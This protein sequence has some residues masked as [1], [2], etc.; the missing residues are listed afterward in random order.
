[1]KEGKGS[2]LVTLWWLIGCL[3]LGILLVV[4]AP[5]EARPSTTENRMLAGAPVLNKES[6]FSGE[7]FSGVEDYMSD[8][9]FERETIID[10]SDELLASFDLRTEEQRLIAEEAEIDRL[11]TM[12]ASGGE[13]S[14]TAAAAGAVT[15]KTIPEPTAE[16]TAEPTPE[17]TAEPT[18]EPTAEPTPEPTA[19]PTP[20]PTAEPTPEP[21]AEPTPEPTTE[22]TPEPTAEPTAE[23]TIEPTRAATPVPTPTVTPTPYAT[24][25][26]APTKAPKEIVPLEEGSTYALYLIRDEKRKHKN[27]T[28]PAENIMHFAG[29]LNYLKTLL[30]EDGEIHYMQV[31]VA[32]VGT[33]L[34]IN[35]S[36]FIG[37][38]STME[39][40]LQSQVEDNIF[41]HNIPAILESHLVAKEKDLYFFTDHHWTP[42]GAWYALEAV[43]QARGL[44]VVG[45]DEY[46][47]Q[48]KLMDDNGSG[49][50]D[51]I[52]AMY[53]LAPVSGVV[54]TEK[55]VE[56]ES[57]LINYR[58]KDYMAFLDGTKTPWRRFD[59][60]YGT[61]RKALVICDSF[62][63][64]FVPYLL[65][66]YDEVHMTDLRN[67]YY[68]EEAA[69]GTFS[70]LVRYH[71]IDDIYV[72][73]STSNGINAPNSLDVFRST[74][75]K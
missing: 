40:A 20:E 30:P 64:A 14:E 34:C 31:P 52:E 70:E 61:D 27:Y 21:T 65:P 26:P 18:P 4:L 6:F 10:F 23:P 39:D 58:A 59:T 5:K 38:E 51:W 22:L 74:I 63:N 37:W 2:F 3:C 67:S 68:D 13:V 7:F 15:D 33:R 57:M 17:P 49:T 9:F 1:M 53:P 60:G 42:K 46:Q 32:A 55:T 45:Y 19:E 54:I 71:E 72:V 24:M 28:Y 43:M 36:Q 25:T 50:D 73:L 12:D 41:I 47:Y 29:S 48:R 11:L 75:T 66:Y 8:G 35:R 44:P 56:H 69:G 16:P 62:G